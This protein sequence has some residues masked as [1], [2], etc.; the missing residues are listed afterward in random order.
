MS[1]SSIGKDKHV[2]GALPAEEPLVETGD[3]R[4]V[5]EHERQLGVVADA[6][7]GEHTLGKGHPAGEVDWS[8]GLLVGGEDLGA[9][10]TIRLGGVRCDGTLS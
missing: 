1:S 6:A 5:D 9:H 10:C 3:G 8:I 7:I 4:L 2:G